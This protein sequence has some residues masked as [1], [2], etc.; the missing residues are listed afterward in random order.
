MSTVKFIIWTMSYFKEFIAS[1]WLERWASLHTPKCK[2]ANCGLH[3]FPREFM[4]VLN[5]KFFLI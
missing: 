5:Y 4:E 2:V 3:I 1:M